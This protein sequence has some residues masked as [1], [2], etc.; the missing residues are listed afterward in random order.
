MGYDDLDTL[1]LNQPQPD[2]MNYMGMKGWAVTV[3]EFF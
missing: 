2:H 3:E 1:E